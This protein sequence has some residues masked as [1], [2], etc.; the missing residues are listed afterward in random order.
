MV[1][2]QAEWP[3]RI[4]GYRLDTSMTLRNQQTWRRLAV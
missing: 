2:S 3:K 4:F 1:T